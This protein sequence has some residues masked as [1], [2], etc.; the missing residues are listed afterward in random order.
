MHIYH[1]IFLL[2][3]ALK[4]INYNFSMMNYCRVG[5]FGEYGKSSATKTIQ[6]SSYNYNLMV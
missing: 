4:V 3:E 1:Y 6:T 5:K 2:E